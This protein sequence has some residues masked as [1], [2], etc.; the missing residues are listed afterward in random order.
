MIV[1]LIWLFSILAISLIFG[2]SPILFSKFSQ[3]HAN[4][5]KL[6]GHSNAL[7]GGIFLGIAFFHLLP[8]AAESFKSYFIMINR[9]ELAEYPLHFLFA[10]IAYSLILFIEKI[11]FDSHSLIDHDHHQD[12]ESHIHS[13]NN[14]NDQKLSEDSHSKLRLGK[15]TY[16]NIKYEDNSEMKTPLM[17]HITIDGTKENEKLSINQIGVKDFI[18]E[19]HSPTR[20]LEKLYDIEHELKVDGYEFKH[21]D[22]ICVDAQEEVIKGLISN[23]GQFMAFMQVRNIKSK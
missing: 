6:I 13:E 1:Q 23:K 7:S 11:A 16:E 3:D 2:F 22:K 4:K 21:D 18:S 5:T 15:N 19:A 10:F 12:K 14:I 9:P 17:Q 20:C 8:E